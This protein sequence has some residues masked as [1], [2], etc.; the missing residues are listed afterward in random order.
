M[1]VSLRFNIRNPVKTPPVL[2]DL[3]FL[4]TCWFL[5]NH[6][7]VSDRRTLRFLMNLAM[8]SDIREYPLETSVKVSSSLDII[9]PIK[10]P[11][12]H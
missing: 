6:E 5:M 11:P 7:M 1:K 3:E 4:R 2:Y 12:V 10:N 8:V 9:N